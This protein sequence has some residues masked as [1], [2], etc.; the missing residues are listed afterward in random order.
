MN[1]GKEE[2]NK[3]NYSSFKLINVH[4]RRSSLIR[5]QFRVRWRFSNCRVEIMPVF[6]G[7]ASMW[8]PWRR[9]VETSSSFT[10]AHQIQT[11]HVALCSRRIKTALYGHLK[12]ATK[13]Q[14]GERSR[15]CSPPRAGFT[16]LPSA[17]AGITPRHHGRNIMLFFPLLPDTVQGAIHMDL[18]CCISAI[19]ITNRPKSSMDSPLEAPQPLMIHLILNKG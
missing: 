9:W 18:L 15:P 7:H 16:P 19:P 14:I 5:F 1:A 4:C 11:K 10:G 17:G 13:E 2:I 12:R 6:R 8:S 3:N